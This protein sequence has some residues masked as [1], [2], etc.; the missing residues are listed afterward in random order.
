MLYFVSFVFFVYNLTFLP[1]N[2]VT[3]IWPATQ[4][5]PTLPSGKYQSIL[6]L[7]E[8]V[9]VWSYFVH[10]FWKIRKTSWICVAPVTFNWVLL[11]PSICSTDTWPRTSTGL[12]FKRACSLGS[13]P[14]IGTHKR[15]L[16]SIDHLICS[17]KYPIPC[18]HL[19]GWP[20]TPGQTIQIKA[21]WVRKNPQRCNLAVVL[22]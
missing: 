18:T 11:F 10:L 13:S 1:L 17:S 15:L 16:D 9:S 8:A 7:Y 14:F 22:I 19:I 20:Q 6:C 3:L 2:P 21:W 12:R 5:L 4:P